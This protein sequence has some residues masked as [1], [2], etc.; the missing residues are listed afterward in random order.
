[1][2]SKSPAQRLVGVA[3]SVK[4]LAPVL[5]GHVPAD[6]AIAQSLKGDIILPDDQHTQSSAT[7]CCP[8]TDCA[9]GGLVGETF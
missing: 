1:M 7:L 3:N 9:D 2:Q 8:G 6:E 4:Q 5:L